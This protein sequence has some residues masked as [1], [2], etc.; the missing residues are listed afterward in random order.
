VST[1]DATTPE[2]FLLTVEE[3][4]QRLRIGRTL[5]FG[6]IRNGAIKSVKVGSLRRVRPAD[7]QTYTESL[8]VDDDQSPDRAA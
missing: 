6:L 8:E 3:A 1:Y 2:P 4:A 7:L 5:M